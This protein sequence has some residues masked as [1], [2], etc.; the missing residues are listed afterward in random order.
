LRSSNLTTAEW[1]LL[2]FGVWICVDIENALAEN[3]G[4]RTIPTRKKGETVYLKITTEKE[5]TAAGQSF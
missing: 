1:N 5:K 2:K 3:Y 4:K